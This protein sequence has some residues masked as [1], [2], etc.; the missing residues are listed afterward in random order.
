MVPFTKSIILGNTRV[1]DSTGGHDLNNGAFPVGLSRSSTISPKSY[2]SQQYV[3]TSKAFWSVP[4]PVN[5]N[6]VLAGIV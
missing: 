5:S 3:K 1:G 6:G 2:C 4:S